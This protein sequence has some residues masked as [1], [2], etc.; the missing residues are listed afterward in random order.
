MEPFNQRNISFEGLTEYIYVLNTGL[1]NSLEEDS[2]SG[3][4]SEDIPFEKDYPQGT[5]Y[6]SSVPEETPDRNESG[7]EILPDR[8][9]PDLDDKGDNKTPPAQL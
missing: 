6:H 3:E 4:L 7:E 1:L 5:K 8:K 2:A 9:N